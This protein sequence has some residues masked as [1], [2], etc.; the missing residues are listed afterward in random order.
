[1]VW[2]TQGPGAIDGE[3]NQAHFVFAV[4]HDQTTSKSIH[5]K[6]NQVESDKK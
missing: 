6:G 3:L 2:M 4:V 5:K 1:M